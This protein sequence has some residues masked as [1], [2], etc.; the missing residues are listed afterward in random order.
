MESLKYDYK[1]LWKPATSGTVSYVNDF[2]RVVSDLEFLSDSD[3][4]LEMNFDSVRR[5][6]Q[7]TEI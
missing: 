1:F 7:L 2:D 3:D 4:T 6:D 5:I